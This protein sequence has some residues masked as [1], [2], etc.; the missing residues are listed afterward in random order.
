MSNRPRQIVVSRLRQLGT[1]VSLAAL[2]GITLGCG[3]SSPAGPTPTPTPTPVTPAPVAP[4]VYT[5]TAS[6]DTVA[7]DGQL[8][9]LALQAG[10]EPATLRLRA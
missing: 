8:K 7:P 10:L 1:V 5:L 3:E 2:L 4:G 6:T 9:R